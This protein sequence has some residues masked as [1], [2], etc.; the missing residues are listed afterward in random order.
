MSVI[1]SV[2]S[3]SGGIPEGHFPVMLSDEMLELDLLSYLSDV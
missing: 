1:V 3:E 2:K